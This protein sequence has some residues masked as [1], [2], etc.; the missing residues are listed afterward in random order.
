MEYEGLRT[1][2][3]FIQFMLR[4][5]SSAEPEPTVD[6]PEDELKTKEELWCNL[7]HPSALHLYCN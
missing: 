5:S 6:T 1:K 3:A 4:R 7:N 2:D